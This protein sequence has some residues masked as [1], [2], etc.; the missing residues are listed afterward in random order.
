MS[1]WKR[2]NAM[3]KS[4]RSEECEFLIKG[5]LPFSSNN[6]WSLVKLFCENESTQRPKLGNAVPKRSQIVLH[7]KNGRLYW[8]KKGV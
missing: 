8:G 4:G 6:K 7:T 2:G 1:S 5:D 3:V